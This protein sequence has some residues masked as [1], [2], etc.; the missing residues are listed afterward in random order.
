[1]DLCVLY[2][3][4]TYILWADNANKIKSKIKIGT[5]QVNDDSVKTRIFHL[6][7]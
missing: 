4:F 6:Q 2:Y 5:G 7:I 3:I 1:M